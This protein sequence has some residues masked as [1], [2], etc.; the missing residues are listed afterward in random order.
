MKRPKPIEGFKKYFTKRRPAISEVV[1]EHTSG[2]IVWR[3]NSKTKQIEILLVQDS[4]NRWTIPKGH[5]EPGEK[6]RRTAEREIGEETGLKEMKVMGWLGKVNFRYRR[7]D[8]LVLMSMQIYLVQALGDTN[9]LNKEDWMNGI[10][11]YS[12]K[13]TLD[14]IEYEDIG[15]VILL[16]LKKIRDAKL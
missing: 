13:E 16:G 6:P 1:R 4:K 3:R 9:K 11:W 10:D 5:I 7:Q 8:I 12:T 15:K 2:G 14:K